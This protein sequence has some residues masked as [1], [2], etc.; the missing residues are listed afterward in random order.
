MEKKHKE[1]FQTH[2]LLKNHL[3]HWKEIV[4]GGNLNAYIYA[5]EKSSYIVNNT[6]DSVHT[7]D[8]TGFDYDL[9]IGEPFLK[10]SKK[11]DLL[12]ALAYKLAFQ[13]LNPFSDKVSSIR[14]ERNNTLK[15]ATKNARVFRVSYDKLRI[16]D[17]INIH[18]LP[19][20]AEKV[21]KG[22]RV[23]D[24]FDV[25]KGAQHDVET[26]EDKNSNLASEIKFYSSER[27]PGNNDNKD[28]VAESFLTQDQLY[29]P[30]YSDTYAR[31][32]VLS[33]MKQSGIKGPLNGTDRNGRVVYRPL[34][35]ELNRREIIPVTEIKSME[36]GDVIVDGRSTEEI[37]AAR[38]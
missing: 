11:I 30:E 7:L 17:T 38:T 13:G 36:C 12:D 22:F 24:W 19:F 28:L 8:T 21:T 20:E 9:G 34:K 1:E 10:G 37:L 35:I 4:I 3:F 27:D 15:I 23:Y 26:L 6:M 31:L 14:L 32:K 2:R 33:M 16:F 29:D 18:D 5:N 25:N